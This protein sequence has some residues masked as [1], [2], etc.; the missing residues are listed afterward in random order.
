MSSMYKLMMNLWSLSCTFCLIYVKY[1]YYILRYTI[2][3]EVK[4]KHPWPHFLRR[5]QNLIWLFYLWEHS[6]IGENSSFFARPLYVIDLL[7]VWASVFCNKMFYLFLMC[8]G[9]TL[10][11]QCKTSH[12]CV[13][14]PIVVRWSIILDSI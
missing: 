11:S 1:I 6:F 9:R 4:P 5:H 10:A 8:D 12:H 14:D 7:V 13:S 3:F 2:Y